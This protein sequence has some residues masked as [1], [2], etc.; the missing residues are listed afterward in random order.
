MDIVAIPCPVCNSTDTRV[1]DLYTRWRNVLPPCKISECCNCAMLFL[2]PRPRE[3]DYEQFYSLGQGDLANH[4]DSNFYLEYEESNESKYLEILS[5]ISRDVTPVVSGSRIS[6][7]DVGCSTGLFVKLAND[8]GYDCTGLEPSQEASA[9]ARTRRNVD[10][11][12]SAIGTA[13]F[14]KASFDVV[15]SHHVLEHLRG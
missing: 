4:I 15:H 11:I 6:I 13:D 8:L 9:V 12:N 1:S 5:Q 3:N 10:V 7:L 14:P 2:S